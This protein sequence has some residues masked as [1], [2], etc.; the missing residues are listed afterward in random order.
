MAEP[1]V[2]AMATQ[3][4]EGRRNR[5]KALGSSQA[6]RARSFAGALAVEKAARAKADMAVKADTVEGSSAA[7]SLHDTLEDA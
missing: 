1:A 7:P 3:W 2:A 4:W 6:I 5:Q